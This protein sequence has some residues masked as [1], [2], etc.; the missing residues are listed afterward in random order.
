MRKPTTSTNCKNKNS[1]FVARYTCNWQL[2]QKFGNWNYLENTIR[3]PQTHTEA[4]KWRL[5]S[6]TDISRNRLWLF[7]GNAKNN[8]EIALKDYDLKNFFEDFLKQEPMPNFV[9]THSHKFDKT[10]Y[11]LTDIS[12]RYKAK[13]KFEILALGIWLLRVFIHFWLQYIILTERDA[14]WVL[15]R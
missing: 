1:R 15:L 2:V 12:K 4:V 7:V 10:C 8:D 11:T 14:L 5:L 6:G 9:K 3:T 13:W